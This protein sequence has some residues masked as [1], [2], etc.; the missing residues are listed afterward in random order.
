MQRAIVMAMMCV[1]LAGCGGSSGI[2]GRIFPSPTP[3]SRYRWAYILCY[4][5]TYNLSILPLYG[6]AHRGWVINLG[7]YKNDYDE[8]NNTVQI[9]ACILQ[10]MEVP[11][12]VIEKIS[13]TREE[14]VIYNEKVNNLDITWSMKSEELTITV[15][16][17]ND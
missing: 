12:Y 5:H 15:I 3:I 13:N 6:N 4:E 8:S 7:V 17:L 14:G 9:A 16:D 11:Q 1:V 10:K 2:M